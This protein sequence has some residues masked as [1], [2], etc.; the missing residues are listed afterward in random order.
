MMHWNYE[1][2]SIYDHHSSQQQSLIADGTNTQGR[3]NV[4]SLTD[5]PCTRTWATSY[6]F[7]MLLCPVKLHFAIPCNTVYRLMP[8]IEKR[9]GH[10]GQ[11]FFAIC[12]LL[13]RFLSAI[14]YCLC[15]KVNKCNEYYIN[16]F[17]S[18]SL[19]LLSFIEIQSIAITNT[20]RHS[21]NHNLR[22]GKS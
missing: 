5:K 16:S 1:K 7:V 15:T 9:V 13:I 19:D 2:S 11:R 20:L 3:R 6:H 4:F 21:I 12:H 22:L 14:Y 18:S 8:C 17:Q 10:S